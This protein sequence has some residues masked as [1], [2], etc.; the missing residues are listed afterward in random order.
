MQIHVKTLYGDVVTLELAPDASVHDLEL[1][2]QSQ[3]G[4]VPERLLAR[5]GTAVLELKYGDTRTLEEVGVPPGS[6]LHQVLRLRGARG[7]VNPT[8][9]APPPPEAPPRKPVAKCTIM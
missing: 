7:D 3:K 6:T 8:D 2:F 5:V 4:Y 9:A 1:A